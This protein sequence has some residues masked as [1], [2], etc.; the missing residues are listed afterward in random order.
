MQAW[1]CRH[2]AEDAALHRDHLER[3]LV[4]APVGRAAAILSTRHSKPRSFASRMVVW[5]QT[6]VVMPVRMRLSMPLVRRI[7][8][9]SVAQNAL[10]GLV[11][12]RLSPGAG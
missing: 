3:G 12:D 10:A 6:S 8:S 4:V 11:D 7:S 1:R 9:R 2:R 5:T